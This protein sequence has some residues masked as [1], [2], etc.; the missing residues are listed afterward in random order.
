MEATLQEKRSE[1]VR[2]GAAPARHPK[3][4]PMHTFSRRWR[5]VRGRVR[6]ALAK[7]GTPWYLAKVL[8]YYNEGRS[9]TI[10]Q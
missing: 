5:V 10:I 4:L 8:Q 7:K 9:V 6:K 2:G 3:L 1:W